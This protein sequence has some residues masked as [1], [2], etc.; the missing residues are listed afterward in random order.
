MVPASAHLRL[1]ATLQL[2]DLTTQPLRLAHRA[3]QRVARRDPLATR[4][5]QRRLE[6]LDFHVF[7]LGQRGLHTESRGERRHLAAE[8]SR[9]R[10]QLHVAAVRRV[11]GL[12]GVQ[13]CGGG[14]VELGLLR[15]RRGVRSGVARARGAQL[16]GG[17][18]AGGFGG[19]ALL[20]SSCGRSLGL[21][22]GIGGLH[23]D[24]SV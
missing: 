17:V 11:Q 14:F 18:L 2:R 1:H 13:K 4:A 8:L 9:V 6:L 12:A 10:L 16:R 15:A 22:S 21:C 24:T 20:V 19:G 7:A 3:A 5:L 23:D